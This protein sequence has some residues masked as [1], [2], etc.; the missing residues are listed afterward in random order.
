MLKKLIP[1]LLLTI[2]SVNDALASAESQSTVSTQSQYTQ[3]L[4]QNI[5]AINE[6]TE[7]LRKLLGQNQQAAPSASADMIAQMQKIETEIKESEIALQQERAE[8]SNLNTFLGSIGTI[9]T[10]RGSIQRY[11]TQVLPN[12][13]K[14]LYGIKETYGL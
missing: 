6:S 10:L 3:P 14:E 7:L 9:G 5:Q 13:I 2:I 1:F 4:A 8:L 12:K 11:D